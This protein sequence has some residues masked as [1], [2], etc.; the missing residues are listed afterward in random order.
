MTLPQMTPPITSL[1]GSDDTTPMPPNA[2]FEQLAPAWARIWNEVAHAAHDASLPWRDEAVIS[3]F[4][5]IA[6]FDPRALYYAELA[7]QQRSLALGREVAHALFRADEIEQLD[8]VLALDYA[9]GWM[10]GWTYIMSVGACGQNT[11]PC[12]GEYCPPEAH[13]TRSL[14]T[15]LSVYAPANPPIFA[16]GFQHCIDQHLSRGACVLCRR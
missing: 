10:L 7:P 11:L 13:R 9:H 14:T 8:G 3:A 12:E 4:K 2:Y 6:G 1:Y 5:R 15:A 16:R